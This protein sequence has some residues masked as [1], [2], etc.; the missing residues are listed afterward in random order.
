MTLVSALLLLALLV[1][2]AAL[3]AERTVSVTASATLKVPNDSAAVTLSFSHEKRS[4]GAAL[5]ATSA[6]LRAVIAAVQRIEGV[7]A[8]DV[9]SGR[10][11]V[12]RTTHGKPPVFR[13]S[14]GISVTLHEPANAGDLISAAIAA[15]ATGVGGPTYFVGDTEAAFAKAL[16]AAFET[17]KSRATVLATQ[18]GASLGPALQIDEGEGAELIPVSQE[19]SGPSAGCGTAVAKRADSTCTGA[20]PP[21]KPGRSTVS[22]T[23]HVVFEL[24]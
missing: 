14:Q 21:T 8:G 7:G 18:A 4:R 16:A 3:A 20:T 15:G 1:P 23:V 17:A 11:S 9:E 24:R 2:A 22:A 6:G 5:S 13:A 10:V 19:K 12:R